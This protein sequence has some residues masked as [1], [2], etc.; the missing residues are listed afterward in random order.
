MTL[1]KYSYIREF[2]SLNEQEE[3]RVEAFSTAIEV[4]KDTIQF[5]ENEQAPQI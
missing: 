5:K 4:L 1:T 2:T 3:A